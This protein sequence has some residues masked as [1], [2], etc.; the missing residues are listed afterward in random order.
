M[1]YTQ[2]LVILA[3]L[4]ACN[5]VY[6]SLTLSS[7][8]VRLD[9]DQSFK[10]END[11]LRVLYDFQ[12]M[13]G[14]LRFRIYNKLSKPLYIN[15][16]ESAFI[17]DDQFSTYWLD[18]YVTNGYVYNKYF[19]WE[20]YFRL[21][22]PYIFAVAHRQDPVSFI[23]PASELAQFEYIVKPGSAYNPVRLKSLAEP[24][25]VL[26]EKKKMQ[27]RFEKERTPLKFRNYLTFSLDEAGSKKFAFT[28]T[29]WVSEVKQAPRSEMFG[30]SAENHAYV[31]HYL[32]FPHP[33]NQ[34]YFGP[35]RFFLRAPKDGIYEP[36]ASLTP[37]RILP[38]PQR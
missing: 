14:A 11:T 17:L 21:R 24:N 35:N 7:D 2:L 19:D 15:W 26:E 33:K 22:G 6:Q 16:K 28:H 20:G 4:S 27:Y 31:E 12:S 38:K 36:E 29:F 5:P 34:E 18:E 25:G 23:P 37:T 13:N 3:F 9:S 32:L 8:V 1:R 30:P 10:F